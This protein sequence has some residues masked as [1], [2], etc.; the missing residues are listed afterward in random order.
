MPARYRKLRKIA[1][2]GMAEI[3]LATQHGAEGFERRVVLKQILAPL[4]ADPKFRHMIV[5]EAHVAMSLNHSNIVQV[6]D[7]GQSKGRY[8]LVLELVDGWDLNQ[9]ITRMRKAE[10][11]LPPEVSLYVGAEVCRA[12]NFAHAQT[13]EGKPLGIVHRDVSPHNVLLSEHGEVKLTDFGI[14][15]AS[16]GR[17]ERTGQGIIKGKLAFMSPEQ[18][19]GGELD[20]R[21]DLFSVGT[22]LYLMVT[23]RRPFEAPT[24]LEIILR[25]QQGSF[26]PPTDIKP[27]LPAEIARIIE[28]AMKKA[29][30]DR[31]QTGEEMLLD[32]EAAQRSVYKPSGQTELRRWL[33][34]LG[35]KDQV[36]PISQSAPQV[37]DVPEE[38]SE[39]SEDIVF[40]ASVGVETMP[41]PIGQKGH[42]ASS[43]LRAAE[44]LQTPSMFEAETIPA[45]VPTAPDSGSGPAL[46]PPPILLP[47]PGRRRWLI[48]GLVGGVGATTGVLWL[49][50][51]RQDGTR[52]FAGLPPS[53]PA[54]PL[55]PVSPAGGKATPTARTE[56]PATPLPGSAVPAG[57]SGGATAG[58]ADSGSD[59][60]ERPRPDAPRDVTRDTGRDTGDDT[61]PEE[62]ED[63]EA[64]LKQKEPDIADKVIGA[65]VPL[66]GAPAPVTPPPPVPAPRPTPATPPPTS[67]PASSRPTSP[68]ASRSAPPP[69]KPSPP[70]KPATPTWKPQSIRI[71]SR[72][73]GAVVKLG[74]RVLGRAPINLRFRPGMSYELTFVKSGYQS[75][76]KRFTASGRKGQLV[77]AN[78]KKR[79]TSRKRRNFFQRLLGR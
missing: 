32:L 55:P 71:D 33:M 73:D 66:P 76:K 29:P 34:A 25:V 45:H 70:P 6:L 26:P 10:F 75:T 48:A 28:R 69:A 59:A 31:Y 56:R 36:P 18:A 57:S 2:G 8:Y 64:L 35:Q 14:A 49:M 12:L 39:H 72:P 68:V 27:E 23:G 43:V 38:V 7:L 54:D 22:M 46:L 51:M 52:P 15:K 16:V 44:S 50:R 21:S 53:P 77:N 78:L 67:R 62:E 61:Q 58:A 4:L 13:R 19:S 20:A 11:P 60:H 30:S 41:P 74:P 47:S 42:T 9:I 40:E 5:D 1:D 79:P 63:E 65:D 17:R 24:D 3:F 37:F